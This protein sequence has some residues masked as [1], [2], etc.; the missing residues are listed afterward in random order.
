MQFMIASLAFLSVAYG[1][2]VYT[3]P[4]S[5]YIQNG[6]ALQGY[7]YAVG[8]PVIAPAA[9]PITQVF[10]NVLFIPYYQSTTTGTHILTLLVSIINNIS[11]IIIQAQ[12]DA[13]IP[14]S[15]DAKNKLNCGLKTLYD[16]ACVLAESITCKFI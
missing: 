4:G 12:F 2:V 15:A 3:V 6:Y 1:A 11:I 14:Q 8:A 9:A 7:P 16:S 13:L 10:F 5:P